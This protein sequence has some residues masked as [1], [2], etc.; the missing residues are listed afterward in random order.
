MAKKPS[1]NAT[2]MV[3]QKRQEREEQEIEPC[4]RR[5]ECGTVGRR[6]PQRR[7]E[8]VRNSLQR[9]TRHGPRAAVHGPRPTLLLTPLLLPAGL[10]PGPIKDRRTRHPDLRRQLDA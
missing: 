1:V 9:S 5:Q 4:G 7:D 2:E 10:V 6:V 3:P 8:T